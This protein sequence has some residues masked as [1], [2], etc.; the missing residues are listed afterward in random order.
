ME[1]ANQAKAMLMI[2]FNLL[3]C[4]RYSYKFI[5]DIIILILILLVDALSCAQYSY[6]VLYFQGSVTQ[7]VRLSFAAQ[8]YQSQ[9]MII[10]V[11]LVWYFLK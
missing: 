9:F 11:S 2:K 4:A 6:K 3:S 7:T 8:R 1:V 10:M 5:V